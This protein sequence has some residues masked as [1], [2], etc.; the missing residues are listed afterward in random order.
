MNV[1]VSNETSCSLFVRYRCAMCNKHNNIL[2]ENKKLNTYVPYV[3]LQF[4]IPNTEHRIWNTH[5]HQTHILNARHQSYAPG[6]ILCIPISCIFA[7]CY[8]VQLKMHLEQS[9]H[10]LQ[11]NRILLLFNWR[12]R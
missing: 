10:R 9:A 8:N 5:K 12:Q 2:C 4:E 3:C 1:N 11:C 7:I 6:S